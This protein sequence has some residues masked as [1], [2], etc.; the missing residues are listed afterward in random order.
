VRWLFRNPIE[1][2]SD[3]AAAGAPVAILAGGADTLIPRART[4]ALRAAART[5]VYDRTIAGAGH[6]DIYARSEVQDLREALAAVLAG[7]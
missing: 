4:D 3:L 7:R 6:N 1:A 2:A 5:L